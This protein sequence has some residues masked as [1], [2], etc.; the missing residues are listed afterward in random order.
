MAIST[1]PK[2]IGSSGEIVLE[3]DPDITRSDIRWIGSGNALRVG[4]LSIRGLA[5]ETQFRIVSRRIRS[6]YAGMA[7]FLRSVRPDDAD[8]I[9]S[10]AIFSVLVHVML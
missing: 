9:F 5:A 6:P 10:R 1:P 2:K 4:L 8:L 7:D 3:I